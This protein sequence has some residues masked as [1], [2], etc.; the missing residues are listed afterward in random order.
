MTLKLKTIEE[1]I[2]TND[3]FMKAAKLL[4]GLGYNKGD[5]PKWSVLKYAELIIPVLNQR[6]YKNPN[7][8]ISDLK[9]L[10]GKMGLFNNS[11]T[12]YIEDTF[13]VSNDIQSA[14]YIFNRSSKIGA[15]YDIKETNPSTGNV[16][17]IGY[18]IH[19]NY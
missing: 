3:R 5:R 18:T 10:A 9:F 7:D 12:R 8:K 14:D 19:W 17:Y 16:F 15:H 1:Y 11:N 4:L 2:N 13:R 6:E